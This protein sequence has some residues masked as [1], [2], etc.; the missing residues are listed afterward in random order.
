MYWFE[1]GKQ[2]SFHINEV[3]EQNAVVLFEGSQNTVFLEYAVKELCSNKD[4]A[5]IKTHIARMSNDWLE[6][7]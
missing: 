5:Y 4:P 3:I 1:N 2:L 7:K 6:I